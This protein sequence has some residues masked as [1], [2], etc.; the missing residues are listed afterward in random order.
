MLASAEV[1][2][3]GVNPGPVQKCRIV[4]TIESVAGA[5]CSAVKRKEACGHRASGNKGDQMAV[6]DR[7]GCTKPRKAHMLLPTLFD[8]FDQAFRADIER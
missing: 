8:I 3:C 6:A 2:G 7:V 1:A 4:S 5:G